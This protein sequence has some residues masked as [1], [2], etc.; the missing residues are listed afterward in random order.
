MNILWVDD[1][2]WT[3]GDCFA[4]L[5]QK[6]HK[7]EYV[8]TLVAAHHRLKPVAKNSRGQPDFDL[9]V[10]DLRLGTTIPPPLQSYYQGLE[11]GTHN[12]GQ[13]L[14]QWLWEVAGA[15]Q[16]TSGPMHCYISSFPELYRNHRTAGKQEFLGHAVGSFILSKFDAKPSAIANQ[17]N[18]IWTAWKILRYVAPPATPP[19]KPT[20]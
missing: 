5:R 18:E 16:S 20:P 3:L 14:G 17:L 1:E 19:K 7:V 6:D 9:V 13:S 10:I 15:H 4:A 2:P 8:E 12:E 11:P